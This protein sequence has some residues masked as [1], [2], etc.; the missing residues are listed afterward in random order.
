MV[1]VDS[2]RH[3]IAVAAVD[4]VV[5]GVVV[6][7]DADAAAAPGP[8]LGIATESAVAT[9]PG[10]STFS[11]GAVAAGR[12]RGAGRSSLEEERMRHS[13]GRELDDLGY[14][15]GEAVAVGVLSSW[16]RSAR[17]LGLGRGKVRGR[18]SR[19]NS[20]VVHVQK[21][22]AGL[23]S[24]RCLGSGTGDWTQWPS[25]L[26]SPV[27]LAIAPRMEMWC[28]A[29]SISDG[30][31]PS[32]IPSPV[33]AG[34]HDGYGVRLTGVTGVWSGQDRQVSFLLRSY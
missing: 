3:R 11:A 14:D 27:R 16:G 25:W 2:S 4:V 10:R 18:N 17:C 30:W 13:A 20:E 8:A 5:G 15:T 22:R 32:W 24:G 28:V 23:V 34:S 12:P 19:N 21:A 9:G 31:I 1:A 26:V 29:L 6:A 7:A 33:A